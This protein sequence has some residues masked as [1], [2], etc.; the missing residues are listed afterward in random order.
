MQIIDYELFVVVRLKLQERGLIFQF[1]LF[2]FFD[3]SQYNRLLNFAS[4]TQKVV[5][6]FV[7]A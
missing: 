3:E 5:Y 2:A 6:L 4:T 1:N 7:T